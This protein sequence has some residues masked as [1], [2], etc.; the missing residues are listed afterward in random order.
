MAAQIPRAAESWSTLQGTTAVVVAAQATAG[1]PQR[2]V[3]DHAPAL[4]PN[5]SPGDAHRAGTVP[6]SQGHRG[7]GVAVL[8]SRPSGR[9]WTR[10]ALRVR[11]LLQ[12]TYA[13][14]LGA[15]CFG[16]TPLLPQSR[17]ANQ[18]G[19][20]HRAQ[21]RART[22]LPCQARRAQR[23][24]KDGTAK[25][26]A[27]CA[28]HVPRPHQTTVS[29][30]RSPRIPSTLRDAV[31]VS[32]SGWTSRKQPSERSQW[33]PTTAP[34]HCA[35]VDSGCRRAAACCCCCCCCCCC[36]CCYGAVTCVAC[37]IAGRN[38]MGCFPTPSELG[39]RGSYRPPPHQ[40]HVPNVG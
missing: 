26:T 37:A 17:V 13:A 21:S 5:L 22:D 28:S 18:R 4:P 10:C 23:A 24:G 16:A 25:P 3:H 27:V 40:E 2:A 30:S 9:R 32:V 38:Q 6:L 39:V 20:A 31:S 11:P 34:R 7:R 12:Q 15:T 1:Q 8:A 36:L 19:C 14:G 35:L 29:S 33:H